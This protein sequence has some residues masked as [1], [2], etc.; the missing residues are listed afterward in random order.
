MPT[1]SRE[2]FHGASESWKGAGS[3]SS[4]SGESFDGLE[5]Q[6]T[7][8]IIAIHNKSEDIESMITS[9]LNQTEAK[10]VERKK[11]ME[12]LENAT[13]VSFHLPSL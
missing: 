12:D 3:D 6:Q 1:P 4:S 11:R 8:E 7:T 2:S 5:P 10:M 13:T 9:T